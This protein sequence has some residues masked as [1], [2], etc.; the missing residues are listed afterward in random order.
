MLYEHHGVISYN[1]KKLHR[2]YKYNLHS[3][4]L[5]RTVHDSP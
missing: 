1:I 2:L 3:L 4:Y 5:Q